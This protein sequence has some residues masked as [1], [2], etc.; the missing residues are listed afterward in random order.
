MSRVYLAIAVSVAAA[1]SAGANEA[2]FMGVGTFPGWNYSEAHAV[3]ADGSTVVGMSM[4]NGQWSH[5]FRWTKDTGIVDLGS[6]NPFMD[7]GADAVSADGSVV[8]GFNAAW[9]CRWTSNGGMFALL[10]PNGVAPTHGSASGITPDGRIIV[11]AA[12]T[13]T[14]NVE[15]F[16]WTQKTG[17]VFLG[18]LPGGTAS[19]ALAVSADGAVIVGGATAPGFPNS[20]AFRW[21][22]GQMIGLGALPG[23][24]YS[25]ASAV[26]ADG[27]IVVG[28]SAGSNSGDGF[29]WTAETGIQPLGG[30]ASSISAD[31]SVIVGDHNGAPAFLD[32][33]G[34][35]DL[36]DV[37]V[38]QY[39]LDLSAWTLGDGI[40]GVSADG[41]TFVGTGFHSGYGWEGWIAHIPEPGCLAL[42]ALGAAA[43]RRRS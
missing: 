3:S 10:D 30:G 27:R 6:F 1:A 34:W 15:A 33:N 37:L 32:A 12:H 8:V 38:N 41:R 13:P 9:A 2:Y 28:I 35:H 25:D 11:G 7:S 40:A 19:G 16:H 18:R 43:G 39:H 21:Q 36:R 24:N 14:Y 22:S 26:S 29:R 42:L 31:G 4:I 20:E 17:I 5:A 23:H